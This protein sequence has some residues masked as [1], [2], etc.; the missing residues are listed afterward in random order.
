[1]S[2]VLIIGKPNSGKSLLFNRLTGMHQKVANFPGVTVEVSSARVGAIEYQDFPGLYSFNAL[3]KDEMVAVEKFDEALKDP[4]VKWVLIVLDA[5]RLERSLVLGLQA[6]ERAREAGR[7][8]IFALNMMDE[9]KSQGLEIRVED[10]SQE[11]GA[12]IIP[13]SARKRLGIENLVKA[14]ES[15][16]KE[17]RVGADSKIASGSVNQRARELC[18]KYG[19]NAEVILAGQSRLDRFFLSSYAGGLVFLLIM[20]FLFQSIFTWSAP[21]MDF[22]ETSV[23]GLGSWVSGQVPQ[24]IFADFL[25]QAVFGGLGSFLVFLPQILVLT[26]IVGVLEDSGYLA[27]AA[28]I[29][30]RP[31]HYFGLSGKSFI[32]LI[33]GYA[34]AIPAL[35]SARMIESPKKRLL[36]LAAVPLMACSARLPVYSLLITAMI[37][38]VT[39]FGGLIGLQG[40]A[41]FGIFAFG[42]VVALVVTGFLGNTLYRSIS[43]APFV[44]ELPPYRLPHWKPLV[45]RSINAAYSFL[46]RAAVVIFSVTV[47]VWALGYF[48]DGSGH[49]ETS[50]LARLGQFLEPLV[51]PLG[52]TWQY[53]VA[54]LASFLAREVFVGTLGTLFGI[55]EA[56]DDISGLANHIQNSG[57]GIP[58]AISLLVFYAIALQCAS[59]VAVL[60]RESGSF[61]F[62]V[63]TFLAYGVLAYVLAIVA[64]QVTRLFI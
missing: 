42:L 28:I 51:R 8:C 41:F 34:C 26:F 35:I 7:T 59:T 12:P 2:R 40:L 27:R 9:L 38:S 23:S 39:Y 17:I 30:H 64:Y 46:S 22:V 57:F 18:K 55:S 5:T 11:L 3:T 52:L 32:P 36:T 1:M 44:V 63:G 54:I 24:G 31:L 21:L 16:T 53:G 47:V 37:P 33:S 62:A 4:R 43:D 15:P 50:Y 14:L 48:P 29:C 61:K 25:E 56:G 13:V 58:A 60:R 10:L 49:L 6:M 19:P 20:I 45:K